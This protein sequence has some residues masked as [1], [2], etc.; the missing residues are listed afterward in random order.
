MIITNY[1]RLSF[2]YR[3]A[4]LTGACLI[5]AWSGRL[6]LRLCQT[7]L[8]RRQGIA[9]AASTS[10]IFLQGAQ[11]DQIEDIAIGRIL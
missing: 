4:S 8:G 11:F 10:L 6:R 1:Q 7:S 9:G 2:I 3:P 5:L